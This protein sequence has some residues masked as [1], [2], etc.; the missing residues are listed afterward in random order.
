MELKLN[1]TLQKKLDSFL[2]TKDEKLNELKK[3]LTL[4]EFNFSKEEIKFIEEAYKHDNTLREYIY[5][6]IGEAIIIVS[7]GFWTINN[8]KKD[9]CYELPIILGWG[10]KGLDNPRLCPDVWIRRIDTNRLRL[11]LGEMIYSL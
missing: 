10:E 7:G 2:E 11:P 5:I 3:I 8:L 9:E 1:K 4:E 6:Y